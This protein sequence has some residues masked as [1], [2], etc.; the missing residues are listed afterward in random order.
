[1]KEWLEKFKAGLVALFAE[2][3]KTIPAGPAPAAP[4]VPT[5]TLDGEDYGRLRALADGHRP[6]MSLQYVVQY[7]IR[8][9]LERT[10]DE[11]FREDLGDP[12]KGERAR[13][14]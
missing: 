7:A 6:R 1:M 4:A 9:L 11:G 2:A 12:S 13:G 8:L 14:H 3:E 10:R 5:V